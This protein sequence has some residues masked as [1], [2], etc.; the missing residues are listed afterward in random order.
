MTTG[1]YKN[2][3][4]KAGIGRTEK[5]WG[6]RRGQAALA[7]AVSPWIAGAGIASAKAES[8]T[9][10]GNIGLDAGVADTPITVMT[11]D[12]DKQNK[13]YTNE[14][15]VTYAKTATG[16]ERIE[17][18]GK[19]LTIAGGDWSSFDRFGGGALS[20]PG[21]EGN[22]S[23]YTLSLSGVKAG[24]SGKLPGGMYGAYAGSEGS[25]NNNNLILDGVI[26]KEGMWMVFGGYAMSNVNTTG[27]A[28][29]NT[30]TIKK[31]QSIW[32]SGRWLFC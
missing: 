30:V 20:G 17:K 6:G 32:G 4:G 24:Y 10:R 16:A 29:Y 13:Y 25:S 1:K 9:E 2:Y 28:H 21:A 15:A 31:Q 22:I 23:G 14:A 7:L 11:T 12:D 3:S 26:A 19:T 27:N 18:T 5:Y 8:T